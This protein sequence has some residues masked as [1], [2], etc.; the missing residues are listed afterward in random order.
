MRSY[1]DLAGRP[2][3]GQLNRCKTADFPLPSPPEVHPVLVPVLTTH[4][5]RMVRRTGSSANLAPATTRPADVFLP[6][7]PTGTLSEA[8]CRFEKGALVLSLHQI[9]RRPVSGNFRRAPAACGVCINRGREVLVANS[10]SRPSATG[11]F[12][13]SCEGQFLPVAFHISRSIFS[14][15]RI[16]AVEVFSE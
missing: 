8:P 6:M 3:I 4:A 5:H 13:K 14:S 10:R 9:D 2:G 16:D 12:G 7:P 1:W 11:P 15:H